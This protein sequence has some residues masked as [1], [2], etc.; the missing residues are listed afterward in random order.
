[1][2][3]RTVGDAGIGDQNLDRADGIEHG[4]GAVLVCNIELVRKDVFSPGGKFIERLPATSA[5]MD[6]C[7]G[8]RKLDRQNSAKSASPTRDKNSSVRQ[9][10]SLLSVL[11]FHSTSVNLARPDHAVQTRMPNPSPRSESLCNW[12]R[13]GR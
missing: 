10:H 12:S 3:W 2:Q 11:G 9:I 5:N 6:L 7:A 8:V 1:M 4:L 13:P